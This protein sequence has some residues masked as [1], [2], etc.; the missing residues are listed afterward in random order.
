MR[1]VLVTMV[2][3]IVGV[4]VAI[5]QNI[6]MVHSVEVETSKRYIRGNS[7]QRDM[8]LYVD[9]LQKTHPYYADKEHCHDLDKR[10]QQL[11]RECADID[12][13]TDFR[14]CLERVASSL[15]DGH[16]TISYWTSYNRIFPI[17]LSFDGAAPA[18]IDVTSEEHRVLLGRAV[19]EINGISIDAFKTMARPLISADNDVN[20][21]NML[22]EY[23]MLAEFW[24]LFGMSDEVINLTLTDGSS[25]E[26]H[27]IDKHT[28]R[29]VQL[30]N[31]TL[32]RVTAQRG[33]LFDYTIFENDGICYLQF[34]QFADRV[35]YP[36]Y[37][38][39]ARFDDFLDEMFTEIEAHG[40]MTLVVDL[41]YNSGGNSALGDVLLSWLKRHDEVQGYGVDVRMSELLEAHYPYYGE[42]TFGGE[43]LEHGDVYDLYAIDQ[44]MVSN[45]DEQGG[46][47]HRLNRDS[48]RIFN[49]NVVFIEGKASFSSSTLL[50]TTARDNGIGIIIGERS[51]GK[52]S[53]YGDIL[54]CMLPNTATIATVSHKH[55][56]R[57]NKELNDMEYI[58]PDVEIELN[59][60]EHDLAWSWII[61]KYGK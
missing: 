24:S 61:E 48:E 30:Q 29:I 36:Q 11:Y 9:M 2:L 22:M 27:A 56:V 44:N 17:R 3:L 13:I 15:N 51:G 54:Y 52:P 34:N 37:P 43:P 19:A 58:V 1:R 35:I 23:M 28:L 26:V 4:F 6:P 45:D 59:D 10:A 60:P 57:P 40:I 20:F 53:H 47:A 55:F 7:Y 38:Q 12:N 33:V 5:G 14:L 31:S 16:T 39:L 42:F 49:G 21:E 8:L 46:S 25:V 50:L 32:K 18:I 41:Q